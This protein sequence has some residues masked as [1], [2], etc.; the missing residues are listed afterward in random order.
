MK[1]KYKS[2]LY[3]LLLTMFLVSCQEKT[4][5][6]SYNEKLSLVKKTFPNRKVF[7]KSN[8]S[9]YFTVI[10]SDSIL[11]SVYVE[12]WFSNPPQIVSVHLLLLK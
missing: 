11:Y 5:K 3:G 9:Q 10:Q 8:D 4:K 6:D 2:F 1:N 12:S 7:S